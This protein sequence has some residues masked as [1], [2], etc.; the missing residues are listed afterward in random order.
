VTVAE[1]RCLNSKEEMM[2]IHYASCHYREYPGATE[3]AAIQAEVER[4][5]HVA[6]RPISSSE[7]PDEEEFAVK[8]EAAL[9]AA[10]G[11]TEARRLMTEI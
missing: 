1:R 6:F 8:F 7:T 5:Q 3:E 2:Y 11:E 10:V 9:I 4:Y